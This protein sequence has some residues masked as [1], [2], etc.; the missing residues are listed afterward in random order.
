M[1]PYGILPPGSQEKNV[2]FE[3]G[4]QEVVK[5]IS[6]ELLP[7]H[8]AGQEVGG[9]P[10]LLSTFSTGLWGPAEAAGTALRQHSR[11][12]KPAACREI[13]LCPA[14]SSPALRTTM[15]VFKK[16][17][18]IAKEGVVGAVE[19]TKQGV[20]EAAEKTK[21][22]GLWVSEIADR[23]G[24]RFVHAQRLTQAHQV[25]LSLESLKP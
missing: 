13:Q 12:L 23:A 6:G 19:K 22:G 1:Q 17:F 5:C 21:E 20:T 9:T 8:T 15:D 4:L 11:Q 2:D 24:Y 25:P 3:V 7:I 18:S 10:C 14:R 16:G